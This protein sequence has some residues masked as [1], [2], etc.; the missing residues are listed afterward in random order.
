MAN[1]PRRTRRNLTLHVRRRNVLRLHRLGQEIIPWQ[2][3]RESELQLCRRKILL[4]EAESLNAPEARLS[5]L[6]AVFLH[7]T[8]PRFHAGGKKFYGS[9]KANLCPFRWK[10]VLGGNPGRRLI[11]ANLHVKYCKDPSAWGSVE[12]GLCRR[13]PRNCRPARNSQIQDEYGLTQECELLSP[14]GLMLQHGCGSA[15]GSADLHLNPIEELA[16]RSRP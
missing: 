7:A 5:A 8:Q 3:A 16:R 6:L 1:R 11:V 10:T 4:F 15:S 13:S 12:A 9:G 14:G 2:R